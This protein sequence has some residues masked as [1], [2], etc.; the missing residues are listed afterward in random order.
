MIDIGGMTDLLMSRL[1]AS[2][3]VTHASVWLRDED[4]LAMKRLGFV[5]T[6][7]PPMLDAIKARPFLARLLQ[8]K[9]MT[10]EGLE[11]EREA[12][13]VERERAAEIAERD[14]ADEAGTGLQKAATAEAERGGRNGA[15]AG[16][17]SGV[18]VAQADW[19][20][21][22]RPSCRGASRCSTR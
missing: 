20:R 21:R 22:R 1:E 8:Q 9:V 6:A 10:I 5:G 18:S 2:R 17:P 3:Q 14:R 7:P 4:G 12:L 19:C 16:A 13:E 11:S 15:S